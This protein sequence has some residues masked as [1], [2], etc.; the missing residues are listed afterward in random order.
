MCR[1]KPHSLAT[2]YLVRYFENG[3]L[4]PFA[5][6]CSMAGLGSFAHFTIG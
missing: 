1:P 4:I 3:T 2:R 6:Y 5:L